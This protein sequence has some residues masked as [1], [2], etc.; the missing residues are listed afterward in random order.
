MFLF[1]ALVGTGHNGLSTLL[2][3]RQAEGRVL[4]LKALQ[5][6]QQKGEAGI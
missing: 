3:E 6:L 5:G 1:V 2:V 4:L